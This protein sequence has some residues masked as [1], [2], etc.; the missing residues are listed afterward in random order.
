MSKLPGLSLIAKDPDN[1]IKD[2]RFINID[3]TNAEEPIFISGAATDNYEDVTLTSS[4]INHVAHGKFSKLSLV[5]S[6]NSSNTTQAVDDKVDIQKGDQ[7]YM[8]VDIES[9]QLK[10]NSFSNLFENHIL[11]INTT[12]TLVLKDNTN[13]NV[14]LTGEELKQLKELI[15]LIPQIKTLISS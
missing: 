3:N 11:N 6:T 12:T 10:T 4:T 5:K 13:Q 15:P 14:T 9:G 1:A 2:V 7:N 8:Y